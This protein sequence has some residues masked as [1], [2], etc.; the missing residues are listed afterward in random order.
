MEERK[1]NI[2]NEAN[3]LT[4]KY[5]GWKFEDIMKIFVWHDIKSSTIHYN[6]NSY[7][8]ICNRLGICTHFLL[9]VG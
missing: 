9:C 4:A 2:I 7:F 8:V 5:A 1:M 3:K 6:D